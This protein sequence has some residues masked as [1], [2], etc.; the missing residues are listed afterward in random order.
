MNQKWGLRSKLWLE[1]KGRPVI[2]DGR[3]EMLRSIQANGSI[4]Q[5]AQQTGIPYRRMRGAIR[6]M[7]S[8]IGRPVV[9]IHR[10]G[11]SGGG[12][13]LTA[14]AHALLDAFEKLSTGFQQKADAR[15]DEIPDLFLSSSGRF[16]HSNDNGEEPA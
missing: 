11:D 14:T 9:K 1:Y 13:E 3:K 6:E 16:R 12:A 8:I 7:E 5:A 15:L 4:K 2:G 10:G